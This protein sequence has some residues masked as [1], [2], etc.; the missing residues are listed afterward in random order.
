MDWVASNID[1]VTSCYALF[2][3]QKHDLTLKLRS[4]QQRASMIKSNN[5]AFLVWEILY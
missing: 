3:K 1:W 4:R 2:M 5:I